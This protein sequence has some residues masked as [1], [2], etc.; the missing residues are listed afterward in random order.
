MA[1][2]KRYVISRIELDGVE[3]DLYRSDDLAAAL[4]YRDEKAGEDKRPPSKVLFRVTDSDDGERGDAEWCENE[5]GRGAF[6]GPDGHFCEICEQDAE[7]VEAG[8]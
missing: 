6:H 7:E 8:R 4:R 3:R 5:C 2:T 1:V